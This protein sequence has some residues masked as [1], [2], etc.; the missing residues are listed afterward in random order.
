MANEEIPTN[1]ESKAHGGSGYRG[2]YA[3]SPSGFLHVG[4]ASTALLAWLAARSAKGAFFL[5]IEDTDP[6]RSK[7]EFAQAIEEDLKWLG[8]P[9][10]GPAIHQSHRHAA[11]EEALAQLKAAGLLF[12]CRCTRKD[13]AAAVEHAVRAPH[14]EDLNAPVYPGTCSRLGLPLEGPV[15]LRAYPEGF[16]LRR[17]DGAYTYTLAV[18]VDDAA[19]GITEVVRGADLEDATP[20]QEGLFKALGCI[21][22]VYR[23]VPLWMGPDG[24]RLS[25]R[26]GSVAVRDWR[27]AGRS[28]EELVGRLAWGLG[29]LPEYRPVRPEE[30]L[31]SFS[32]EKVR[33]SPVPAS[34]YLPLVP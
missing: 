27:Q 9:W 22:P 12:A 25:K 15:V 30:L 1:G 16:P 24:H 26:H 8:L 31:G 18:V 10:D 28:A 4:N 19:L 23:H 20:Q 7:P 34:D 2:R 11:Y 6:Q 33:K 29:L 17:A 13:L 14:A 5:R 32:W 3:P 21:P